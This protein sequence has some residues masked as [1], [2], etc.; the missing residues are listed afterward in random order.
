MVVVDNQFRVYGAKNL[1]V[2]DAS[3]FPR[4]PECFI[5]TSAYMIT[6]KAGEVVLANARQVAA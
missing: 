6:E 2:V 1:R 5:V 3:V 4:I